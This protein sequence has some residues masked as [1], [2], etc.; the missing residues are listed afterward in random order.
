MFAPSDEAFKAVPAKTMPE[1]ASNKNLPKSVL[2]RHALPGKL[3]AAQVKNGNSKT[4]QGASAALASAGADVTVE[5]AVVNRPT[6]PRPTA[7][8]TSSTAC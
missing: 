4:V 6:W 5:E 7:P 3:M 2:A 8:C 1:L